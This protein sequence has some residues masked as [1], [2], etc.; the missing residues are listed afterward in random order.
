MWLPVG[1]S[2]AHNDTVANITA[3][4]YHSIRLT[5]GNS[6]DCPDSIQC[7]WL[8]ASEAIVTPPKKG[9]GP[10]PVPP[11][12]N[13]GAACW[14]FGQ[15]L[16]DELEAAGKLVPIGLTDTAIGGQRIEEYMVNDTSMTA[17]SDRSGEKS[18]EWNGRLYGKQTLPF[19]DMTIKGWAWYQGENNMGGTKGSAKA[20]VGYSCEQVK[21][22]AGW[23]KVW[24]ETP[25]TTDPMAPFGIVT[26]ASSGSEGGADIGAMRLAQ[27]A[28]LGVLPGPAGSGMEHTFLAQAFDL[29]DRWGPGAGPCQSDASKG[30]WACCDYS[31]GLAGKCAYNATTC[32]GREKQV[33]KTP[34]LPRS[35]GQ[36]QLFIA[37]SPQECMG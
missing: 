18:P 28:G 3:G 9:R 20:N 29:D 17:C 6:G 22:V 15:R 14:Y 32:A 4:K 31:W 27:T 33:R 34:S 7:P 12:F 24:S 8:T 21:L 13:F 23:R 19:V 30:G 35:W 26:L 36:L 10:A 1:N 2:F 37:V 5:A 11:L 16:S 25:G